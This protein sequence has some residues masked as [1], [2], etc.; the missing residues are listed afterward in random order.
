MCRIVLGFAF[1]SLSFHFSFTSYFNRTSTPFATE[2]Y[3]TLLMNCKDTLAVNMAD[4]CEANVDTKAEEAMTVG[5]PC[6][7]SGRRG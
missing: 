7:P 1:F 4:Y 3:T 2:T 5:S 6:Y